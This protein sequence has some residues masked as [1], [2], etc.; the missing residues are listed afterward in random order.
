MVQVFRVLGHSSPSTF[1]VAA[2]ILDRYFKY[3]SDN[4][5][6]FD[7]SKFYLIGVATVFLASKF[8]DVKFINLKKCYEAVGRCKFSP[9]DI[10]DT[11]LD[12]LKCLGFRVAC[13]QNMY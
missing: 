5:I 13:P 4:N 1:F 3:K 12:I 7:G 10:V 2:S 6:K 8:E 9:K 11:E